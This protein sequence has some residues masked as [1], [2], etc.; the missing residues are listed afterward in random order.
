VGRIRALVLIGAGAAFDYTQALGGKLPARSSGAGWSG[1]FRLCTGPRR[2][3][4]GM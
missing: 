2:L 4:D 1:A 3:W